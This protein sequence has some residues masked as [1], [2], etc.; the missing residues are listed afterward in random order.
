MGVKTQALGKR[1]LAG[2]GMLALATAGIIG[3]A[4]AAN[5]A[6]GNID[7]GAEGSITV[8]K[9]S[10]PTT[11]STEP[12]TGLEQDVPAGA[13]LINGV[14]FQVYNSGI[15][16]ENYTQ[17]QWD[18]IDTLTA[19]ATPTGTLAGTGVTDN[20]EYT[21][22]ELPVGVYYVYETDVTNA[23]FADGTPANIATTAAPWVVVVPTAITDNDVT[24]WV[25][26]IHVYPKNTTTTAPVKAVDDSAAVALGD[27]VT[28]PVTVNVPQ[29]NTAQGDAFTSI[30]LT[31]DLD[32]RLDFV[33]ISN[34]QYKGAAF[35]ASYYTVAPAAA[36]AN[37]PVVTLTIT[38]AGLTYLTGNSN[39]QLTF[40]IVTTVNSIDGIGD[41]EAGFITNIINQNINGTD[42][43]S[44]EVE[45]L[46]GAVRI[47]KQDATNDDLLDGAVFS[48]Y[49]TE[50]DA[51]ARTNPIQVGATDQTTFETV[52]G[53]VTIPGLKA[54]AEG[55]SYWIVEIEA[56]AGYVLDQTPREVTVTPGSTTDAFEIAVDN[57]KQDFPELPITGANGAL[58]FGLGGAAVLAIGLGL[59]LRARRNHTSA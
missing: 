24:N 28:W 12:A 59:A 49:A 32:S 23:T 7:F 38:P 36:T 43:D 22:G 47:V 15:D 13:Q 37:G 33:S 20:G 8:H 19:P 6:E 30:V 44:N 54:T 16:L 53:V 34:V 35:D 39:G 45:T 14:A 3:G 51:A 41:E 2:L 17:A 26:D 55:T 4:G 1:I 25:Y 57:T 11:P 31:D 46:W 52:D 18:A 27:T 50:A 40:D 9:Y 42:V 21:F 10:Q 48:V 5:A 56:P 29:I 58:L